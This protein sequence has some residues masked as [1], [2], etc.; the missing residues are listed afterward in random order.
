MTPTP[1]ASDTRTPARL[2]SDQC[3]LITGGT[4]SFGNQVVLRLLEAGARE[5]RIFSRDELKQES[6]RRK[7]NDAGCAFISAMCAT[8]R[9]SIVRCAAWTWCSMRRR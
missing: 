6:M 4:G 3:V 9:R 1:R 7:L 8:R 2:F 5:I